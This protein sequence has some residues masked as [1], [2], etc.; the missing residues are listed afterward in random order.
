[1]IPPFILFAGHDTR[2]AGYM[3]YR[4]LTESHGNLV[5][6]CPLCNMLLQQ[7]YIN[8]ESIAQQLISPLFQTPQQPEHSN[9]P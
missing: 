9:K 5:N 1:M 4:H 7:R 3:Q 6:C 8:Y 2:R